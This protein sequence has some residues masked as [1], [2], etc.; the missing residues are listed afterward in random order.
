MRVTR[1][2]STTLPN[3]PAN[4]FPILAQ[5]VETRQFDLAETP[6]DGPFDRSAI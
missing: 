3:L 2:T 1:S 5:P 6:P 4:A